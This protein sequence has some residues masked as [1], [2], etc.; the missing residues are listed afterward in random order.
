[1]TVLTT[2]WNQVDKTVACLETAD[3][4]TYANYRV[5]VVDNGSDDNTS[6]VVQSRFPHVTLLQNSENL[7]FAGG[8]N[9][10]FRA[11]LEENSDYI[12]LINNDTLLAPDC[13][14]ELVDAAEKTDSFGLATAKIYYADRPQ[15]IWSIGGLLQ[16]LL[17]EIQK[18]ADDQTDSG[19]WETLRTI[20]FAPLCGVL[21]AVSAVRDIGLLDENYFVYYED[22][23]YC[24]RLR[25]AGYQLVFV[26]MAKMWHAVSAS[27]GGQDSAAERYWMGQ[28]S[29]RYYRTNST[30]R[31]R[32][33]IIIYRLLSALRTTL[34]LARASNWRAI[35][36]YWLGLTRGWLTGVA[37]KQPPAWVTR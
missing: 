36:A 37:T 29:G 22:M 27:S 9:V 16:P 18:L 5:I 6:D 1:M 11:A 13:L 2:A 31:Q 30:L 35:A 23:D 24:Q 21:I 34:R 3:A 25:E 20:D 10:G 14:T 28:G 32:P 15:R 8:Y 4:L 26:P 33:F 17:L 12:F 19:Q 7:G